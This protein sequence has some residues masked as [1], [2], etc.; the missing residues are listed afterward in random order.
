MIALAVYDLILSFPAEL[1]G[2]WKR[3]F[4][5][6]TILYLSVRYGTILSML[7]EGINATF[8]PRESVVS[9]Q[10]HAIESEVIKIGT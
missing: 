6:G 3:Q 2:I 8:V 7:F 4:G 9:I 5:T 1:R 10:V